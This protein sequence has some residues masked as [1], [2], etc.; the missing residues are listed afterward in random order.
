[1]NS[2]GQLALYMT[3]L[4]KHNTLKCV[5]DSGNGFYLD[6]GE[7]GEIL[8]PMQY[9][10]EEME[11]GDSI[12]VFVFTDS[13]D[14]I[15]ATTE[16]PLA[17]VGQ[18]ASLEV[19]SVNGNVG[20]F[21][22]WGLSKDLLLPFRE[23]DGDSPEAGDNCVVY[24]MAD[25]Q[26]GRIVATEYFRQHISTE[27]AQYE[28]GEEVDLLVIDK[29]PMGY[30]AI[31]NNM[32]VGMLYKSELSEELDYGERIVGYITQ[33]RD[34]GHIDLRRDRTGYGRVKH[35]STQIIQALEANQG[36]LPFNDKSSPESIRAEFDISKK[37]FKQV[38]GFL[39]KN[40]KISIE[41]GGIKLVVD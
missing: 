1:M 24:V 4:G 31:V 10:P 40:R 26:S 34:D 2:I 13:E 21:L 35:L 38:I 5:R 19:V 27:G 39:Y 16:T 14:R 23:Q 9:V 18:F 33:V 11:P 12:T 25:E 20:A 30:K 37:A 7:L 29:T 6:G 32:H 36:S 8:L 41:E 15:V 22:D 28:N 3:E 17:E